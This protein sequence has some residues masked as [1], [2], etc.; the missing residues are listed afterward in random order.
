VKVVE[1]ILKPGALERDPEILEADLQQL[2][3]GQ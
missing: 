1:A 3:V 2:L